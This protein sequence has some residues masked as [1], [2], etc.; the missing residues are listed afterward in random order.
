MDLETGAIK[1]R[2]LAKGEEVI[3]LASKDR[4]LYAR[5]A[6]EGDGD[7]EIGALDPEALTLKPTLTIKKRAIG[8]ISP[9]PELSG[10]G[11]ALAVPATKDGKLHLH[12]V[13]GDT[14]E[15]SIHL[16]LSAENHLMGNVQWA[17]DRKTIYAAL[18]RR[19][20]QEKHYELS[21]AEIT[22]AS[23][24]HRIHPI[25]KA[26]GDVEPEMLPLFFQIALSPDGKTLAVAPTYIERKPKADE[27]FPL[28][29]IDL[30][31]RDWPVTTV[32]SPG[33]RAPEQEE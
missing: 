22:V 19:L 31:Q 4:L 3:L 26:K 5:E 14:L 29:L 10:D 27:G 15:K 8:Q 20:D 12:L 32:P 16:D 17:P 30:T 13:A 24:S 6:P 11:A 2:E 28:H 25:L 9:Y 1:R 18:L 21:V 7:I 23:G 33:S